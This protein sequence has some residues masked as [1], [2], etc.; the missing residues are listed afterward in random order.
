M[1]LAGAHVA[2]MA[3]GVLVGATMTDGPAV[4]ISLAYMS[5]DGDSRWT[6][7]I[8][9]SDG[10]TLHLERLVP[11]ADRTAVTIVARATDE[12][13]VERVWLA[14]IDDAGETGEPETLTS[15]GQSL[16]AYSGQPVEHDGTDGLLLGGLDGSMAWL[17]RLDTTRQRVW[18]QRFSYQEST[19][20][21]DVAELTDGRIAVVGNTTLAEEGGDGQPIER[22]FVRVHDTDGDLVVEQMLPIEVDTDDSLS[23]WTVDEL[24]G[25]IVVGGARFGGPG[26]VAH[27]WQLDLATNQIDTTF[28]DDPFS[29]I[30]SVS[31][32]L[33]ERLFAA[34]HVGEALPGS[35]MVW[36]FE[37]GQTAPQWTITGEQGVFTSLALSRTEPAGFV[38]GVDP[39]Q[40]PTLTPLAVC[41]F[42]R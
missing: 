30:M 25:T 32:A 5:P 9:A 26:G 23:A 14:D 12:S 17:A 29:R 21:S 34:G 19:L 2:D 36:A 13:T 31:A 3:E 4:A 35:Q 42:S 24:G 6:R 10:E 16:I 39:S 38:A 11:N 22:A 37:A 1:K 40:S 41:K 27:L 28:V 18:E 15:A 8:A 33:E 20:V 7:S